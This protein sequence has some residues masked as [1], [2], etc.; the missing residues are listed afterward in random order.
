MRTEWF[1]F[2]SMEIFMSEKVIKN[3]KFSILTKD[4]FKPFDGLKT[5]ISDGLEFKFT[6]TD[7]TITVTENHIF[8]QDDFEYEKLAKDLEVGDWISHEEYGYLCVSEINKKKNI[9]VYDAL[10]VKNENHSYITNGFNSHNCSFVGSSSTLIPGEYLM[11]LNKET[12]DPIDFKY[13]YKLKIYEQPEADTE[14]VIGVD[15]A[16]GLSKDY[17]VAQIF[18]IVTEN[19]EGKHL[20][21]K[22]VAVF[23]DNTTKPRDFAQIVIGIGRYYNDAWLM[24]ENNN[25]CG[26]LVCNFVWH[27]YEYENMVNPDKGTK[28]KLG[29]NANKKSKYAANMR[30]LDMIINYQIEIVDK[31]TVVELNSY[32]EVKPDIYAAGNSSSHDDCITSMNW[33]LMFLD[34]KFYEGYGENLG[35]GIDS[36]YELESYAPSFR[37]ASNPKT[38]QIP[39]NLR[40][41]YF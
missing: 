33:A 12:K 30:L 39:S 4:G 18:K 24:I 22:Q 8:F 1:S 27:D 5:K 6:N 13:S 14:Y 15:P 37:N 35:Q 11:D 40:S 9:K 3:K 10:D 21:L 2:F 28:K 26:G 16:E 19:E 7:I 36:E 25:S 41:A 32:E 17:S 31:D 23:R 29:I 20:K 34:T 38:N